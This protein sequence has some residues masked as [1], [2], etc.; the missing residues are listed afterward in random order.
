LARV[1]ALRVLLLHL[2]LSSIS[3]Q[4]LQ[5]QTTG[6]PS[7][8]SNAKAHQAPFYQTRYMIPKL[9]NGNSDRQSTPN[10]AI[11]SPYHQAIQC[12]QTLIQ[13][14]TSRSC[15]I[16]AQILQSLSASPEKGL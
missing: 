12:L 14:M 16:A 7:S 3:N 5:M 1:S 8:M 9:R 11:F 4:K 15:L 2:L 13:L 10:T 6:R